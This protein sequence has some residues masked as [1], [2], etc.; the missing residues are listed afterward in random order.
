MAVVGANGFVGRE[1][2][3]ALVDARYDVIAL[4]RLSLIHI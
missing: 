2:T 3:V 4:S 1:L